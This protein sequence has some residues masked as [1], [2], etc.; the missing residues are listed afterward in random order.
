[1]V[2]K[3][4]TPH[5]NQVTG[6]GAVVPGAQVASQQ[7]A[8]NSAL[9]YGV[10]PGAGSNGRK[11]GTARF[12]DIR[13]FPEWTPARR[14][15]FIV[16]S[17]RARARSSPRLRAPPGTLPRTSRGPN[18]MRRRSPSTLAVAAGFVVFTIVGS[19]CAQIAIAPGFQQSVVA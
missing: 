12:G 1:M 11:K 8:A 17:V 19:A 13:F 9:T 2:A 4:S 3:D 6:L 14:S 10:P 18:S 16:P 5:T 15:F 7:H